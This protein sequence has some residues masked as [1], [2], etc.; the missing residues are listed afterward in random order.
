MW[1]ASPTS[2]DALAEWVDAAAHAGPADTISTAAVKPTNTVIILRRMAPPPS[3]RRHVAAMCHRT[4]L[5]DDAVVPVLETDRLLIRPFETG[6]LD[7]WAEVMSDPE[8]VAFLGTPP[9]SRE[10]A[11]RS[12]AIFLGHEQLRGWS[13]NAVVEKSSGRLVGRSGLWQPEGWPGL[14]VGWAL[15]RFAWGHGYATE[16][17]AAWRDWAFAELAADELISVIHRDN[18]RSIAVAERIGHTLWREAEV[19]G[20]PCLIYGQ[21]RPAGSGG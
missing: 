14:E 8:V 2:Q 17:A 18:A 5:R 7:E 4:P 6:D 21:R 10:D 3:S 12:M 1:R 15:G 11:W 16:A 20:A 9:M 19:R 13:N